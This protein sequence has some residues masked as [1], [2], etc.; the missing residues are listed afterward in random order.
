MSLQSAADLCIQ[1]SFSLADD[2]LGS[3]LGNACISIRTYTDKSRA[4]AELFPKNEEIPPQGEAFTETS[5]LDT[6]EELCAAHAKWAG[7][8]PARWS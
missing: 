2:R 7:R 8:L 1:L 4:A 5:P 3:S 6:L